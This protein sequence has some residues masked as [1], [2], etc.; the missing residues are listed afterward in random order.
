MLANVDNNPNGTLDVVVADQGS[1]GIAVLNAT[2][3]TV[4]TT[5]Y[6]S[7]GK[8]LPTTVY[9]KAGLDIP[10]HS[11]PTIADVDGDGH[12]EMIV[13]HNSLVYIWDLYSWYLKAVLPAPT[14][15]FEPPKVGN[16]TGS[17][18]PDIIVVSLSDL[19]I[20]NYANGNY[21]VVQHIAN[22]PYAG[23]AFTLVQD[24]D[25]DGYN[26]LIVT[27]TSGT[28]LCYDTLAKSPTPRVITMNQ[29]YS[30]RRC[31][32]AEY[33]P[34]LIPSKPVLRNEYPM[35]ASLNQVVNPTLSILATDFQG[36]NMNITFRTNTTTLATYVNRP[37][38][39][40]TA[41]TRSMNSPGSTYYWT[42]TATDSQ[43][44]TSN[45]Y[46][47]TT[48][49]SPAPQSTTSSTN[50][51]LPLDTPTSSNPLVTDTL[52]SDGFE[53]GLGSW[54]GNGATSWG[55]I[56][57]QVHSGTYSAHATSGSGYLTSSSLDT[58]MAQGIT[59]SFWY[60]DQGVGSGDNVYLRFWNGSTYNAIFSLGNTVP[61]NQWHLYSYQ[62]YD[63]EYL[64]P[65]FRIRFDASSIKS[66]SE[67]MWV[68]D[69][70][71]TAPSR[72]LDYSGY[73]NDGTVHGATWTSQGAV[74]GAYDFDGVNDYISIQDDS[75]L[76]GDGTRSQI[77]IEIW[78]KPM[79]Q[80]NATIIAKKYASSTIGS[81][82][83]R[84]TSSGSGD[85]LSWGINSTSDNAW[86]ELNSSKTILATGQWYHIVCTYKSGSGLAIYVNGSLAA[87]SPTPFTGNIAQGTVPSP[88]VPIF[89][90]PLFIGWDGGSG[91]SGLDT[92]N[93]W[94]NGILDQVKIYPVALSS[95]QI[96]QLH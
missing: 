85:I 65:G 94:L 2:D 10:S 49:P 27:G 52:F 37:N 64:I 29:F 53:S 24:V 90:L 76:G 4:L 75:T 95:S 69:V 78:I 21:S 43:S 28:V 86:H 62:T 88:G 84:L 5:Q 8:L 45:T 22:I 66:S 54:T 93:G 9:R 1:D 80:Q 72:T 96:Q 34:P 30:L 63:R 58:S 25:G 68:D 50:L 33:V 11:N 16:V 18:N 92:R 23:S 15:V 20:Y 42:V 47:F 56:T 38:G 44:T 39:V 36:R 79:A 14:T 35:D 41:I 89:G 70:S 19:Y 13:C 51:F 60:F 67:G 3:G 74:G 6:A 40:Y 17:S 59:V 82:M 32:Y 31:G 73:H 61:E 71:I 57:N 55:R 12:L 7:K 87:N 48:Y 77:S 46:K 81:Y 83:V 26:E 91:R